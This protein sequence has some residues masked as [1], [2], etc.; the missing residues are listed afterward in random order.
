[1][2][3]YVKCIESAAEGSK[4]I[5]GKGSVSEAQRVRQKWRG[6]H[7]GGSGPIDLDMTTLGFQR[8]RVPA[9]PSRSVRV[10]VWGSRD[11][12]R[13]T[14]FYGAS[15]SLIAWHHRLWSFRTWTSWSCPSIF[16]IRR[17]FFL[18]CHVRRDRWRRLKEHY[19]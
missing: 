2:Q 5:S 7:N 6:A 1:M 17:C 3:K 18:Y 9:I 16:Q 8:P 19:K 4:E 13:D 11:L 10:P 12:P 14:S 15:T